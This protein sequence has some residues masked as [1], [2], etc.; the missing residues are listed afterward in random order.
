[1]SSVNTSSQATAATLPSPKAG[2]RILAALQSVGRSLMLPMQLAAFL[3]RSVEIPRRLQR[4]WR[5]MRPHAAR[6]FVVHR[7]RLI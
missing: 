7:D 3:A 2:D 1:M 5:K 6:P 4:L